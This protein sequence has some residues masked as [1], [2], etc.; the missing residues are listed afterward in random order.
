MRAVGLALFALLL[1]ACAAAAIEVW[2]GGRCGPEDN[3]GRQGAEHRDLCRSG[4][5]AILRLGVVR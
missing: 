2:G 5:G 4:K 3:G 1:S